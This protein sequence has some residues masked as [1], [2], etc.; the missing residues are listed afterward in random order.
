[1]KS[2][3]SGPLRQKTILDYCK[4]STCQMGQEV[5]FLPPLALGFDAFGYPLKGTKLRVP[6]V[7]R[8]KQKIGR[9]VAAFVKPYPPAA[10]RTPATPS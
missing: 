8:A 5:I 3:L 2:F 10:F 4:N 7:Y 9:E 6:L 1:M